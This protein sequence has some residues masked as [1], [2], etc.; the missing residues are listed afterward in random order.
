MQHSQKARPQRTL[1]T[2][3]RMEFRPITLL[4]FTVLS[5][6][7]C[8]LQVL[9][10]PTR[11]LALAPSIARL[12]SHEAG[13]FVGVTE[14][15]QVHAKANP[16]GKLRMEQAV[17]GIVCIG[18][19]KRVDFVRMRTNVLSLSSTCADEEAQFYVTQPYNVSSYR[20]E[21]VRFPGK[22]LLID[23]D[24]GTVIGTGNSTEIDTD[25]GTVNGTATKSLKLGVPSEGSDV[26]ER[27]LIRGTG[28]AFMYAGTDCFMAFDEDGE[29]LDP[30]GLS[31][32]QSQ[33]HMQLI[34]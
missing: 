32:T 10:A 30:C 1:Q 19:I 7:F 6:H 34:F 27:V 25:N 21:S 8:T 16:S 22:Y 28:Q 26:F 23:T 29:P 15:G 4:A 24:N 14:D 31:P 20:F 3:C 12:H 13:R 17:D 11:T 9:A 2:S 5:A 18:V 33:V